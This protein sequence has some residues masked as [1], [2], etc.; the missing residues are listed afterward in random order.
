[1]KKNLNIFL[2]IVYSI[3]SICI[4]L[5][6]ITN[7]SWVY[8]MVANITV[9][10]K[11]LV[12]HTPMNV[13]LISIP[14]MII[15]SIIFYILNSKKKKKSVLIN[16]LLSPFIVVLFFCIQ[17]FVLIPMLDLGSSQPYPYFQDKLLSNIISLPLSIYLL[18]TTIYSGIKFF[19]KAHK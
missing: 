6:Y 17:V 3:S 7:V 4:A 2:Y 9:V 8:S 19:A 16:F 14:I 12:S 15:S 10:S 1:M 18:F 5:F 13:L 11:I